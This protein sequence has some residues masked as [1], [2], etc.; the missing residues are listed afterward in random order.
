MRESEKSSSEISEW[1]SILI[2]MFILV[3]ATDFYF[4]IREMKWITLM[5]STV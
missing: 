2:D 3:L 1:M 4:L 5:P